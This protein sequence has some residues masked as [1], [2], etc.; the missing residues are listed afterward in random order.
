M[1][2]ADRSWKQRELIAGYV[3]MAKDAA[4]EL[5]AEAWSDALIGDAS[6]EE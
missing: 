5:E 6:A 3:A 2:D 4:R 1:A